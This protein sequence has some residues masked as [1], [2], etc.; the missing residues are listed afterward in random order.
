[1]ELQWRK[2]VDKILDDANEN[3]KRLIDEARQ[4]EENLLKQQREQG[5]RKAQEEILSVLQKAESDVG[6]AAITETTEANR[7]ANWMILEEKERLVTQILGEVRSRLRAFPKSRNYERYLQKLV[8]DA[9]AV[10]GGGNLEV[11]LNGKDARLSLDFGMLAESIAKRVGARTQL[12]LSNENAETVGGVIVKTADGKI[13][14]D[15]TFEAVL[16]RSERNL[17]LRIAKILFQ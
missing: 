3:A 13:V 11:H 9:G 6:V 4:Y 17:K 14:V 12:K 7:K 1:M 15:N 8:V 10:L 5:R 2:I 16:K